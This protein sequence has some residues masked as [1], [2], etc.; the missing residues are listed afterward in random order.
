MLSQSLTQKI[1]SQINLEFYSS[2]FYLQMSAW[3]DTRG[4]EG[5]S[6]FLHRHAEEE[7]QHMHKFFSFVLESGA[8]PVLGT[9]EAPPIEFESVADVFE[10]A[11]EHECLVSREINLLVAAAFEDKDFSTFNF[12]QWFVSEQH[13]EEHLFSTILDK[14]KMIGTEGQAGFLL[15]QE[16]ARISTA[17]LSEPAQAK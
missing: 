16:I 4:F 17:Q 1:N 13:E 10:A 14:I 5:C 7:L 12:L 11:Y 15:D 2:N 9:I 8:L 3:C 6:A